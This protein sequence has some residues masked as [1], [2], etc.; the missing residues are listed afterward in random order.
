[1]T[2]WTWLSCLEGDKQWVNI[3]CYLLFIYL[4]I[5]QCANLI[6]GTPARIPPTWKFFHGEKYSCQE[7][8]LE[9][10]PSQEY[11][12]KKILLCIMTRILAQKYFSIYFFIGSFP[13]S[14]KANPGRNNKFLLTVEIIIY[15][16]WLTLESLA[17][18]KINIKYIVNGS[19]RNPCGFLQGKMFV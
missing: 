2:W 8:C 19:C 18:Q 10:R 1:M 14:W 7:S 17:V 13:A 16:S 15:F 6:L 3:I 4:F 5:I 12:Q 11:C 9:S